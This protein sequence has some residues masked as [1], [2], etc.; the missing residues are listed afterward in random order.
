MLIS[1]LEHEHSAHAAID[2][3]TR[4]LQAE[5][6][7]VT[8]DAPLKTSNP[9]LRVVHCELA[10]N[11]NP[12]ARGTGKGPGSQ[13]GASAI[14]EAMEHAAARGFPSSAQTPELRALSD[15]T[16]P[17]NP[18]A[19]WRFA[20]SVSDRVGAIECVTF[21]KVSHDMRWLASTALF[22]RASHDYSYQNYDEQ[23]PLL[24][25]R[26]HSTTNGYA[27]GTSRN[28]ALNHALNELVERDATSFQLLR[29]LLPKKQATAIVRPFPEPSSSAIDYLVQQGCS[30]P[31]VTH[32]PS[33]AG[34][35]VVSSCMS[36]DGNLLFGW[37][38]SNLAEVAFE[39]SVGELLQ[40]FDADRSGLTFA[41]EGGESTPLFSRFPRLLEA[42]ELKPP[43]TTHET[44]YPDWHRASHPLPNTAQQL[45]Q[46]G[47]EIWARVVWESVPERSPGVAVV[48][49][50]VPGL[51]AFNTIY[52][53]R[54]VVP[55]GRL[56]SKPLLDSLLEKRD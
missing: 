34:Y 29:D 44:R 39:R 19:L 13:A 3:A 24:Y 14:F 53:G 56:R 40:E 22:P 15:E 42:S 31:L 7:D 51:E 8:N 48:H 12:I 27:A 10:I 11:G 26:R 36:P 2:A 55:T 25:L 43:Q 5:G 50:T 41:D 37:G 49:A 18:D 45:T 33:E 16:S 9:T 52:F 1:E 35:T 23:D 38:T 21:Q 47:Y 17:A 20:R 28:D 6:I 4:A 32:V 30:T 46:K 54:A